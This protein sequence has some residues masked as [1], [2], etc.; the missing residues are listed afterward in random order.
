MDGN[1]L[2]EMLFS[3]MKGDVPDALTV[4]V[5]DQL[6]SAIAQGTCASGQGGGK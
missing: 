2:W 6:A 4:E 5:L 3:I 1:D